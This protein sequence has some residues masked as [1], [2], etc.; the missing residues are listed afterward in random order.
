MEVDQTPPKRHTVAVESRKDGDDR[1]RRGPRDRDDRFR[2]RAAVRGEVLSGRANDMLAAVAQRVPASG[3]DHGVAGRALFVEVAQ[4]PER[5]LGIFESSA[6][7]PAS[8]R[9][10]SRWPSALRPVMHLRPRRGTSRRS[11]G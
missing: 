3:A 9:R 1:A 7:A 4:V 5:A 6:T 11:G 8:C 2:A 10:S